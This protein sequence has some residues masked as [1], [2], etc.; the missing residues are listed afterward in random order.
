MKHQPV[1]RKLLVKLLDE[2]LD[3]RALEP[4]AKLGDASFEKVLVAQ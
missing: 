1:R 3:R 4:Q 2:W